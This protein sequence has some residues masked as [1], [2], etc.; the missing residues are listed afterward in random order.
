[1]IKTNTFPVCLFVFLL[2]ISL[3][4]GGC[5]PN[6]YRYVNKGMNSYIRLDSVQAR[7]LDIPASEVAPAV[8]FSSVSEMKQDIENGDFTADELKMIGKFYRDEKGRIPVPDTVRLYDAAFPDSYHLDYI[9]LSG[10][11]YYFSVKAKNDRTTA[12]IRIYSKDYF[13]QN[14][15]TTY[16]SEKWGSKLWYTSSEKER[17]ATSYTYMD[18]MNQLCKCV[19]YSFSDENQ[20]VYVQEIYELDI[21]YT[22]PMLVSIWTEQDNVYTKTS[23][24]D[25]TSR[26]A[27]E[28]ICMFGVKAFQ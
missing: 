20:T 10:K 23:I 28:D 9:S 21:S 1:M 25:L 2:C 27:V 16:Y 15:Q 6:G 5:S 17:N 19:R 24:S 22:V 8:Y 26:P 11:S 12:F 18:F 3:L 13:E 4:L 7:P 14:L